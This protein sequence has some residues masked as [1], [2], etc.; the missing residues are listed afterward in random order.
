MTTAKTKVEAQFGAVAENYRTSTVHAG[1]PDLAAMARAVREYGLPRVLDAGC[2][3]GHAAAAAA[4]FAR[5]VVA[6]D[7]TAAM[8][9]QT[10]ILAAER[11]LAN[12]TAQQA[13]VEALPFAD[14]AFDLVISRYSAHH[15]ADPLAGLREC[16]RVSGRCGMLL[17]DA[18]G[19]EQPGVDT[20]FQAIELLRD[21]SHVRDYSIPQWRAMAETLGARVTVLGSWKTV[22]D[23]DA[24]VARIGT[25]P[26]KVAMLRDLLAE[27]GD[28]VRA[29]L[30]IRPESFSLVTALLAITR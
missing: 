2:G 9:E 29:A 24:W 5:E 27:A 3:G 11:G 23:F 7:M 22:L 17:A 10:R 26:R 13:D 1:G 8:V 21:P 6:V 25:P 12:L 15:W 4:P 16:L 30:D 28:E 18:M 14:G 20:F 19:F